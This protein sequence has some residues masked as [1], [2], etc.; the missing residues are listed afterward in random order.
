MAPALA[1]NGAQLAAFSPPT[2]TRVRL[3][4]CQDNWWNSRH[5]LAIQ[6]VARPIRTR[7]ISS[8]RE[9]SERETGI[10]ATGAVHLIAYHVRAISWAVTVL[11]YLPGVQS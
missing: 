4:V 9:G 5:V 2:G 7:V 8:C 11:Q 1:K 3:G 10:L 6:N